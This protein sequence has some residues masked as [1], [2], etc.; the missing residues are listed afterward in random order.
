VALGLICGLIVIL[1]GYTSV[2]ALFKAELFPTP[3]R[4]LGVALPYALANAIFGGTAEYAALWFKQGGHE[5]AFYIY[6][7]AAMALALVATL[8][9]PDSARHSRIVD[10]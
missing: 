7:S 4:G 1:S 3:L 9:L 6:V 8:A 5:S 2:S 10:F